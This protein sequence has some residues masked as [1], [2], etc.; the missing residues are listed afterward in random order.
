MNLAFS[1][2]KNFLVRVIKWVPYQTNNNIGTRISEKISYI[3]SKNEK[4]I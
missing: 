3:S 1:Y 2:G 4:K